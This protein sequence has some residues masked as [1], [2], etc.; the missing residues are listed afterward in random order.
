MGVEVFNY[1]LELNRYTLESKER[2]ELE[3]VIKTLSD[4]N[5]KRTLKI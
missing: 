5:I 3:R 2:K 1:A 4:K